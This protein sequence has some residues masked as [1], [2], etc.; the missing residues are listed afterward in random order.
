MLL[1]HMISSSEEAGIEMSL[2]GSKFSKTIFK[3][4]THSRAD[5]CLQGYLML[6]VFKVHRRVQ[7]TG[8]WDLLHLLAADRH[9]CTTGLLPVCFSSTLQSPEKLEPAL[10]R[11][12]S[13]FWPMVNR[14]VTTVGTSGGT[15]EPE[16]WRM[17]SL[18]QKCEVGRQKQDLNLKIHT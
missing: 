17:A 10:L 14:F 16:L 2:K 1:S 8:N 5:S 11:T 15:L 6:H 12:M 9:S 18:T 13:L 3:Q 7:V 4:T